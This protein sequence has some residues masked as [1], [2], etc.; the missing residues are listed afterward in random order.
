MQIQKTSTNSGD[1]DGSVILKAPS[2]NG[3]PLAPPPTL[4]SGIRPTL[5]EVTM[6]TRPNSRGEG[7]YRLAEAMEFNFSG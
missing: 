5:D 3:E 6:R 7:A 1:W 4:S 2:W